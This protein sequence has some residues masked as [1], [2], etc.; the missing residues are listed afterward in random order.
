MRLLHVRPFEPTSRQA[1]LA[2]GE[3]RLDAALREVRDAEEEAALLALNPAGETPVLEDAPP[4]LAAP[5][6]LICGADVLGDY[7]EERYPAPALLPDEPADRAEARRIAR[8]FEKR[9]ADDCGRILHYE[10]VEKR[11]RGLGAP[12]LDRIRVAAERARWHLDY[13]SYL[14][15][16]RHWLAGEKLTLADLAAAAHLSCVDYLGD[17]D[18]T[19]FEPARTWYARM[20]SRPVMR[21]ILK[22]RVPGLKPPAHYDDPDF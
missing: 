9:F 11:R 19:G 12:D 16:G 6:A 15:E 3:K 2:L 20:K 1:R 10:R 13:V 17:L 18:W 5:P 14:A 4:D 21:K 7:L 8:W 22:E